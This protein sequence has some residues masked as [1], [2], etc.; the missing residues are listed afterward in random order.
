VIDDVLKIFR[1]G[2]QVDQDFTLVF[3]EGPG[4]SADSDVL[5][6]SSKGVRDYFQYSL[7]MHVYASGQ[8]QASMHARGS[9]Q[10]VI[11]PHGNS[12][13]LPVVAASSRS[14]SSGYVAPLVSTGNGPCREVD[15]VA[16]LG[17][18]MQNQTRVQTVESEIAATDGLLPV[19]AL[20][21]HRCGS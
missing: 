5:K 20:Q 3:E 17:I 7:P 18:T 15:Q 11:R 4:A 6:L 2:T 19:L 16:P 8:D 10:M 21:T 9:D 12:G 13:I 14:E 1:S